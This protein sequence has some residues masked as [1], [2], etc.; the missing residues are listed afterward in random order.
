M[1]FT[2]AGR[3]GQYVLSSKM[4]DYLGLTRGD[5]FRW[6]P[7]MKIATTAEERKDISKRGVSI[8]PTTLID[9]Q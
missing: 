1:E 8:T 6:F 2:I 9:S 7:E 3:K 5:L 4:H